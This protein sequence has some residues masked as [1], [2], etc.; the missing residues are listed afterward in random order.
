MA[1]SLR[2][3]WDDWDFDTMSEEDWKKKESIYGYQ[4]KQGYKMYDWTDS[5]YL[6]RWFP[7]LSDVTYEDVKRASAHYK[8]MLT[9][10]SV[11]YL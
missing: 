10:V 2:A 4:N 11:S 6:V 3:W 9:L 7:R 5:F 8:S 1:N